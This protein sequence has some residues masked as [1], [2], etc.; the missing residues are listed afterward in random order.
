M[1]KIAAIALSLIMLLAF[2]GCGGNSG[3]AVQPEKAAPL[4]QV[5]K[6]NLE[7]T[8]ITVSLY[9]DGGYSW[10]NRSYPKISGLK[11]KEVEA[12]IN[13]AIKDLFDELNDW[14]S[15]PKYRGIKVYQAEF[16]DLELSRE[17]TY[18]DVVCNCDNILS[19]YA[20]ANRSYADYDIGRYFYVSKS[21]AKT[22][23]LNTG[24]E[25]KLSDLFAAA[26]KGMK[27]VNGKLREEMEHSDS[28]EISPDYIEGDKLKFVGTF[29]GVTED[30]KFY[31]NA[32]GNRIELILDDETPW[33]YRTVWGMTGDFSPQTF[34]INLDDYSAVREK[35]KSKETIFE[36]ETEN[37]RLVS[38]YDDEALPE[39]KT[40]YSSMYKGLIG[41]TVNTMSSYYSGMPQNERD[42]ME[43]FEKESDAKIDEAAEYFKTLSESDP[44]SRFFGYMQYDSYAYRVG[45]FTDVNKYF[46]GFI[47]D[48]LGNSLFDE[49]M[50]QITVY[51]I[52]QEEPVTFDQLFVPGF[53]YKSLLE[54][55]GV[56]TDNYSFTIGS[57]GIHVY[58]GGLVG[59]LMY[60]DIG[61]ENLT[62]FD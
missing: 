8:D 26:S 15:Y 42:D 39:M 58:T 27:Y 41:L 14:S 45:R 2:A 17:S 43:S 25:L 29:P 19:V 49:N 21:D 11:D 34:E 30:Q 33:A 18:V 46:H 20:Y 38:I 55:E 10:A 53:D 35:C 5:R 7:I 6:N 48:G 54:A 9:E 28:S 56:D 16:E 52:G 37:Y 13:Q 4:Y 57:D 44:D 36:D 59:E 51:K 47:N 61:T 50:Q 12:K 23:D 40:F 22:F 24:K 32:Y 31:L 1:K 62:L 60:D 3:L